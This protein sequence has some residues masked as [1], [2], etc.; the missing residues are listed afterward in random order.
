MRLLQRYLLR[1]FSVPL[2]YCLAGFLIFWISFDLIS[3]LDDF[4]EHQT[5]SGQIV[6]Y[7][8]L[9]LP[10]VL[11]V[12]MPVA[13]LLALLYAL[14]NHAR[15]QEITAMRAAGLGVWVIS[16]PYLLVGFA[17]SVILFLLNEWWLPHSGEQA[18]RIRDRGLATPALSRLVFQNAQDNR[19][20][21]IKGY[22]SRS[23]EMEA[24]RLEWILPDGSRRQILA[25]RAAWT[26]GAWEFYQ[27]Q[28]FYYP[29]GQDALPQPMQ[30]NRLVL[31][32][33]RETPELFE[34]E[35]K[36]S[37]LSSAR[38]ARKVSLSVSDILNYRSLHPRLEPRERALLSTQLHARLAAPW[39][40]TIVVLIALPF[41]M[42]PGRRNV[43]VGVASS[44]VIGFV[45][46]ILL[47]VG[48][49]L[50]TARVLPGF[51]AAWLPNVIFAVLG[52][53]LTR[54]MG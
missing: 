46:F 42:A 19:N 38:A 35:L 52:I 14:T 4:Q 3:A 43:M 25:E 51:V 40:C 45:Y 29:P 24:P 34:S 28:E 54:R 5:R 30:T 36:V 33:L 41:G 22:H 16:A 21:N 1:E 27:V 7:Y 26:N 12:V 37:S 50:G 8:L 9:K 11:L 10:E 17:F 39:T 49:A 47:R 32:S 13:L 48:L 53:L 18:E 6:L 44:I 20:W 31:R 15:H 2:V 23:R